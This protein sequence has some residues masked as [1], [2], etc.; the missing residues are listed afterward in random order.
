MERVIE[1]R[2][3][4]DVVNECIGRADGCV[5]NQPF[6]PHTVGD[7][8]FTMSVW[9][10]DAAMLAATYR[11]GEHRIQMDRHKAVSA[12]DRSSFTRF[13]VLNASGQWNGGD[14]MARPQGSS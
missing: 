12:F 1:F 4:V 11:E 9:R 13:R 5:A 2:R 6:T 3:N 7:D 10:D 14:P 8:G